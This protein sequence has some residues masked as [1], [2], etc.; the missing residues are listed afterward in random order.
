MHLPLGH[1]VATIN[2]GSRTSTLKIKDDWTETRLTFGS[3]LRTVSCSSTLLDL[4][5]SLDC[6]IP[7]IPDILEIDRPTVISEPDCTECAWGVGEDSRG[8]LDLDL[9]TWSLDQ[10]A[11]TPSGYLG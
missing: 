9:S 6:L 3:T 2:N 11:V 10:F 5:L 8:S 7:L 4:P 1:G